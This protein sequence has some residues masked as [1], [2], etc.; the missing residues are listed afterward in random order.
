VA[1]SPTALSGGKIALHWSD[2]E[3]VGLPPFHSYT[4]LRRTSPTEAWH[5]ITVNGELDGYEDADVERRQTYTYRLV[6]WGLYGDSPGTEVSGCR[7]GAGKSKA[8]TNKAHAVAAG[9]TATGATAQA[10]GGW[11]YP[12]FMSTLMVVLPLMVRNQ[13]LWGAAGAW[14]GASLPASANAAPVT[15]AE[16][17][18]AAGEEGEEKRD[19]QWLAGAFLCP[20]SLSHSVGR[21]RGEVE[22][23]RR[24]FRS[25]HR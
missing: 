12:L 8:T 21:R 18:A 25:Q 16:L 11:A 22:K 2:P 1:V 9:A 19:N 7:A 13:Q 5:S 17:A 14:L 23:R 15:E 4:L 20:T 3:Q 6:L 10:E 24:R